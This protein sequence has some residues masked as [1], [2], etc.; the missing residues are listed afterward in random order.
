M[1]GKN[2]PRT[3][4]LN[5]ENQCFLDKVTLGFWAMVVITGSSIIINPVIIYSQN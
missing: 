4:G 5:T 3:F 1:Q 2:A